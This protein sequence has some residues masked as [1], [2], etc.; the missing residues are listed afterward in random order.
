MDGLTHAE[1][2]TRFKKIKQGPVV[3]LINRRIIGSTGATG[4]G[5]GGVAGSKKNSL[6]SQ[7]CDNLIDA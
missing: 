5:L 2:L 6:K 4:N 1:A 3:L 7:S